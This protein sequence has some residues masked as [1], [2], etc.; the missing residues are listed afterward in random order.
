MKEL[1]DE[2]VF[3]YMLFTEVKVLSD[4]MS[5]FLPFYLMDI[6]KKIL[7]VSEYLC[8]CTNLNRGRHPEM[9]ASITK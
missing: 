5:A 4:K 6:N 2:F 1:C 3:V 7:F 8:G 9:A